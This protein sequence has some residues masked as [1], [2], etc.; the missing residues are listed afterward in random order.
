M[1][2]MDELMKLVEA[3]MKPKLQVVVSNW[4]RVPRPIV[5]AG[6]KDV[7]DYATVYV[8]YQNDIHTFWDVYHA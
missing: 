6:R 3:K 2:M 4:E 7:S 1:N 8:V 5:I